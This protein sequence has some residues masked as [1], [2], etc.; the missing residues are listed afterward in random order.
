[1][2][3]SLSKATIPNRI[4]VKYGD[5]DGGWFSLAKKYICFIEIQ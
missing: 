4:F 1:M 5:P 3:P 2:N